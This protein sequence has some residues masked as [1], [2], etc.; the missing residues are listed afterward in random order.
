MDFYHQ[1]G[2]LVDNKD[3]QHAESD[4]LTVQADQKHDYLQHVVIYIKL[5]NY[6][7]IRRKTVEPYIGYQ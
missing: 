7:F 5:I 3:A 2:V 6:I 4:W 1:Y